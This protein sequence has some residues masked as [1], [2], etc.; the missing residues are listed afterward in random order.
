MKKIKE[1]WN[2]ISNTKHKMR[3]TDQKLV[4]RGKMRRMKERKGK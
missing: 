4:I 1:K 2:N 3:K